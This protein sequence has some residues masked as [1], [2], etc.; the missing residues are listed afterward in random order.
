MA[1]KGADLV[2]ASPAATLDPEQASAIIRR[3][4]FTFGREEENPRQGSRAA[5]DSNSTQSHSSADSHALTGAVSCGLWFAASWFNH[6][7]R[8]NCVVSVVGDQLLIRTVRAVRPGEELTLS[9]LGPIHPDRPTSFQQRQE[10]LAG[11]GIHCSCG[12]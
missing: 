12:W 7:C 8:P 3:H 6:S 2:S 9:F 1:E 10:Q 4:A 5:D 11:M